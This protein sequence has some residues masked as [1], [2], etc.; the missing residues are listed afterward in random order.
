[1]GHVAIRPGLPRTAKGAAR[2]RLARIWIAAL[3][4]TRH[5]A[6]LAG[7]V[8]ATLAV[9]WQLENDPA[10]VPFAMAVW[11][12][13]A[14]LAL[15]A[16][17]RRAFA[18]AA[19]TSTVLAISAV[20]FL[21]YRFKGF[22]L[23]YHDVLFSGTDPEALAFLWSVYRP[24]ILPVVALVAIGMAVCI[25]LCRA[26]A[27]NRRDRFIGGAGMLAALVALPL[28]YPVKAGEPR[29]FY[30]LQGRHVSAFFVS[31]LD[32][33]YLFQENELEA[34]LAALGPRP[35]TPAAATACQGERPDLLVV[36]SESQVDPR[37]VPGLPV[38]AA[39]AARLEAANG[40]LRPLQ[41]ESF[42]GGT[43]ITTLSFMT[44]LSAWD[45]GWRAPY[46]TVTLEDRVRRALPEALAA[47]GYRSVALL[48]MH[49]GFVNEGAFLSSIGFETVLDRHD[50]G[51]EHYHL[52]DRF[53]LD[54]ASRFVERHRRED[55]RP[56]FLYVQTMF[57]H[58]PYEERALPDIKVPG[59]PLAASAQ[60]AEYLRRLVIARS[61]LAAFARRERARAPD[62][63][64]VLMDFGDHHPM[65]TAPLLERA[66]GGLALADPGSAAYRT[67]HTVSRADGAWRLRTGP[68]DVPDIAF[69]ASRLLKAAGVRPGAPWD[70]LARLDAACSGR[71]HRCRDR[72]LVDAHLR[73]R[74]DAGWLRL[75][76]VSAASPPSR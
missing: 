8:L 60:R 17:G 29:Y 48:P 6:V 33:E 16:S 5:P 59:E 19:A 12:L 3:A 68:D 52:R 65:A 20:S 76:G 43:W 32:L 39:T 27:P 28:A 24:M 72:S 1:M 61:D 10:A 35:A 44:G 54:A 21:K 23:H 30:Y 15:L 53:Y 31:L 7:I 57:A 22:S 75:D 26:H 41:V 49:R 55:G 42:G 62:R 51:A 14:A 40:P 58:S 69:L 46:L 47:C 67:F 36:L 73:Q 13:L 56:L 71:M 18:V 66:P 38:A 9:V 63:G 45:F 2:G 74:V 64:L 4:L 25:L 70:S 34:R 50:I 11:T 37:T